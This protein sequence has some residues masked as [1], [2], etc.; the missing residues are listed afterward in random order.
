VFCLLFSRS[1]CK[2]EVVAADVKQPHNRAHTVPHTLSAQR[3]DPKEKE[4]PGKMAAY[5]A[6]ELPPIP[7][8]EVHGWCSLGLSLL[9]SLLSFLCLSGTLGTSLVVRA[10]LVFR[11]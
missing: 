1:Y 3:L 4:Q 10:S 11:M 8:D 5:S 6:A 7:W 2:S 9:N